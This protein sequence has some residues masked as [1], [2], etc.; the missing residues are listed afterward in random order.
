MYVPGMLGDGEGNVLIRKLP[1]P[2]T[3]TVKESSSS[4][5]SLA[6]ASL[7][8]IV[9][10]AS[11]PAVAAVSPFPVATLAAGL[12]PPGIRSRIRLLGTGKFV[13]SLEVEMICIQTK[14]IIQSKK[15]LGQIKTDLLPCSRTLLKAQHQHQIFHSSILETYAEDD[16]KK[17]H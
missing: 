8:V 1:G 2:L 12:V 13:K 11:D 4:S 14:R 17:E 10:E 9:K 7:A 15:K 6:K 3:I 16:A 5:L